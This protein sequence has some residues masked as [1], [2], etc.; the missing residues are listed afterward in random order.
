MPHLL[1]VLRR[2]R[3]REAGSLSQDIHASL[4]LGQLL[5]EFEAMRVRQRFGDGGKV[6]EERRFWAAA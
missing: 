4:A 6:V 2:V 1:Q 3:H 5:K